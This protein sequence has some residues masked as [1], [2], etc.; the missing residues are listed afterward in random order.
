MGGT[1]LT[2]NMDSWINAVAFSRDG[3]C[4]VSGCDNKSVLVWDALTG[5]EK[6]VLNGH[7]NSVTSVASSSIGSCI[8]SGLYDQ[9]IRVWDALTGEEK[10]VLN[11]HTDWVNLVTF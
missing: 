10:H 2:L 11:S 7:T 3:S 8:V 1:P 5:E 4:I 9:S 6:H